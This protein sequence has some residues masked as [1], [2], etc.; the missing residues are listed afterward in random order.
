[1]PSW[2][3]LLQQRSL[4]YKN[5]DQIFCVHQTLK[6]IQSSQAWAKIYRTFPESDFKFINLCSKK[7]A[8]ESKSAQN[9]NQQAVLFI[10]GIE[11]GNPHEVIRDFVR[12]FYEAAAPETPTPQKDFY[13]LHWNSLLTTKA[14]RK[15]LERDSVAKIIFYAKASRLWSKYLD[16]IERR[17]KQTARNVRK[18]IANLAKHYDEILIV[19]HSY[20][21]AVWGHLAKELLT[22]NKRGIYHNKFHWWMLQPALPKD[23]FCKGG[24]LADVA[25]QHQQRGDRIKIWFS[26]LDWVLS[27]LYFGSRRDFAL[28]QVG[29][30]NKAISQIDVTR[31]VRE[32]HGK[33]LIFRSD[34]DFFMR[35]RTLL[36]QDFLTF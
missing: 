16:D 21:A 23:A 19:T 33:N 27:S 13:F 8:T 30:K 12:P 20:G 36:R 7:N 28:G 24:Q 1:M 11:Y 10:H 25:E 18:E 17:A 35:A 4:L 26:R 9:H 32:A 5:P 3:N 22:K 2:V 6:K 31:T 34:E 14:T 29:T 15:Y